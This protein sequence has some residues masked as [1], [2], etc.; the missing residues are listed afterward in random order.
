MSEIVNI[1]KPQLFSLYES[2]AAGTE[3]LF[4]QILLF[5]GVIFQWFKTNRSTRRTKGQAGGPPQVQ[6]SIT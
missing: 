6:P 3:I 1:C 2:C 4:A 5:I